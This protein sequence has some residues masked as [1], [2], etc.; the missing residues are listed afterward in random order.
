[1]PA[2]LAGGLLVEKAHERAV[3]RADFLDVRVAYL[4]P[5]VKQLAG[6][7]N[8]GVDF[9]IHGGSKPAVADLVRR[10]PEWLITHKRLAG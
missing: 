4:P 1:M 7:L 5:A 10:Q 3:G 6:E 2:I 9:R 8:Q